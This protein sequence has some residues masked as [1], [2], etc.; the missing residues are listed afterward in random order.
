[1]AFAGPDL[2]VPAVLEAGNA[3]GGAYAIS[4]RYFGVF[5]E[6]IDESGWRRLFPAMLR[7]LD[8]CGILPGAR[9]RGHG[10]VCG[11]GRRP[12][13]ELAGMAPVGLVDRPGERVSGWAPILAGSAGLDELFAAGERELRRAAA[14]LPGDPPRG[15]RRPAQPQRARGAG[16][17]PARRGFRLGMLGLGRLP[18]RSRLVH[19]LGPLAPG[20]AAI[21]FRSVIRG[22]YRAT[23][24]EVPRFDERLRCYELHIG[25]THL[26]YCAFAGSDGKTTCTRSPGAPAKSSAQPQAEP[27]AP[28]PAD[29]VS[30]VP[31]GTSGPSPACRRRP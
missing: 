28:G 17:V 27:A 19:V 23:G 29:P 8:A 21:D 7:G 6:N 31:A 9:P 4:E 18:L 11:G 22:H 12:P 3:L 16:R 26:A 25:L 1:M 10:P 2:P 14:D 24:V 20:L 30:P 5:L 13:D 15:A